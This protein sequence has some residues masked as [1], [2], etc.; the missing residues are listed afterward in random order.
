MHRKK[1]C[2]SIVPETHAI[3]NKQNKV[4]QYKY[5][6]A[7]KNKVEN[8]KDLT[9]A[10]IKTVFLEDL[11]SFKIHYDVFKAVDSLLFFE[12]TDINSI[13]GFTSL[14]TSI[15]N[16]LNAKCGDMINKFWA[17]SS[18]R[19]KDSFINE[20]AFK[21]NHLQLEEYRSILNECGCSVCRKGAT[22]KP[23]EKGKLSQDNFCHLV[24][25]KIDSLKAK[26]TNCSFRSLKRYSDI[27]LN[28]NQAILSTSAFSSLYSFRVCDMKISDFLEIMSTKF[29]RIAFDSL[30][31]DSL[32][33]INFENV[34]SESLF[35]KWKE[36]KITDKSLLKWV[37]GDSFYFQKNQY[38]IYGIDSPEI[39]A[40]VS[41]KRY[42][43]RN[44]SNVR[45]CGSYELCSYPGINAWKH[46]E[47]LMQTCSYIKIIQKPL[48]NLQSRFICIV[49]FVFIDKEIDYACS[50]LS[51]GLSFL[52]PS[53]SLIKDYVTASAY[54]RNKKKGFFVLPEDAIQKLLP[55]NYRA[56]HEHTSCVEDLQQT[57]GGLK[58]FSIFC[59]PYKCYGNKNLK[60]FPICCSNHS[61]DQ[62]LNLKIKKS[63]LSGAGLGV[64]NNGPP[65]NQGD[66]ICTYSEYHTGVM[67]PTED[68]DYHLASSKLEY[69]GAHV[70]G[71]HPGPLINDKSIN[72]LVN[73]LREIVDRSDANIIND[74]KDLLEGEGCRR[75]EIDSANVE[76]GVNTRKIAYI[77]ASQPICNGDEIYLAY[78]IKTYWYSLLK[79]YFQQREEEKISNPLSNIFKTFDTAILLRPE[80]KSFLKPMK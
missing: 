17:Q 35:D 38:R 3:K 58:S 50:S 9:Y 28:L 37:D 56:L 75:V 51:E 45:T 62:Y 69:D 16:A 19:T 20:L 72:V 60:D 63:S 22:A 59:V 15:N 29:V 7:L 74:S 10:E 27:S 78:G 1:E 36:I 43:K 30:A 33:D 64:F 53:F 66:Y 48:K 70:L 57:T 14:K 4:A 2:V 34:H 23:D 32:P 73:K 21:A 6:Y 71:I 13:F 11:Q 46:A 31:V 25:H 61:K 5:Y 80:I 65:I 47:Y 40:V 79:N 18:C 76:F 44:I 77:K 42:L 39:G 55:W 41:V 68:R 67:M 52:Y 54:A 12:N 49:K 8:K 24:N 26:Y